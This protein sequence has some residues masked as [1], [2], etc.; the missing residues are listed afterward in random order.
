ML[1]SIL[2]INTKKS[3]ASHEEVNKYIKK[4]IEEVI[5]IK[6]TDYGTFK[7]ATESAPVPLYIMDIKNKD[8]SNNFSSIED[9]KENVKP[10]E[11]ALSYT[12]P[13]SNSNPRYMVLDLHK[14]SHEQTGNDYALRLEINDKLPI[15]KLSLMSAIAAK[16]SREY[17][18]TVFTICK[19]LNGNIECV[20]RYENTNPVY[21]AV[22]REG[23]GI[24]GK[25]TKDNNMSINKILATMD[26]NIEVLM[27]P[28]DL[29]E[30]E[31]MLTAFK[32]SLEYMGADDSLK[33]SPE[34][35]ET[36]QEVANVVA[37]V[38]KVQKLV[39]KEPQ[40]ISSYIRVYDPTK[41]A[42]F[43]MRKIQFKDNKAEVW[44]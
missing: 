24:I 25:Y 8:K 35:H 32:S 11:L 7:S 28:R 16:I 30:Y 6:Y 4:C 22:T 2:T 43:Q 23:T 15:S 38:E 42:E 44:N 18:V 3:G 13:T 26:D 12:S 41:L 36:K 14:I 17:I 37:Q 5:P 34:Y 27:A 19:E 10:T 9:V 21:S 29:E 20:I 31:S 33:D 39:V 40:V 1:F